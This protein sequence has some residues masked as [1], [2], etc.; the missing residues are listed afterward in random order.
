MVPP[1]KDWFGALDGYGF[2]APFHRSETACV[3]DGLQRIAVNGNF[4][5][6]KE[7]AGTESIFFIEATSNRPD[8]VFY[9]FSD[10]DT[11]FNRG[12]VG[13]TN[14]DMDCT[15]MRASTVKSILSAASK[16]Q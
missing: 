3:E 9:K 12:I 5:G 15:W 6:T 11:N 13:T 4:L 7:S 1:A 16:H 10:L 2:G 8:G 14:G